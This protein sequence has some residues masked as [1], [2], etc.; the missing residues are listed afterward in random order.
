MVVPSQIKKGM[1]VHRVLSLQAEAKGSSLENVAHAPLG[2]CDTFASYNVPRSGL[3]IV[4]YT[5][6]PSR[7]IRQSTWPSCS[8]EKPASVRCS[9]PAQ[10]GRFCHGDVVHITAI[11]ANQTIS[12]TLLGHLLTHHFPRAYRIRE[13]SHLTHAHPISIRLSTE[14]TR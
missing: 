11:S 3:S 5:S 1:Q 10:R 9:R 6:T 12:H 14:S 7:S 8:T 4:Q 13:S 2:V